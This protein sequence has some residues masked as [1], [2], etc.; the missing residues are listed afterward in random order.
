MQHIDCKK[1][2]QEILDAVKAVPNKK[3]LVILTVGNNPASQSYVKGKIK[4]CEYCGIPYEHIKIDDSPDAGHALNVAIHNANHDISV[5]GVIVQLP[6]PKHLDEEQYTNNVYASLDVDG[7]KANSPFKPC[8]PEGIMYVLRKELGDL[9]GKDALVI[10]RGK[11]V[12]EPLAKMLLDAN[13][14]VTVAHSKTTN[15]WHYLHTSDII[16]SAVG[17][18]NTVSLESCW[19]AEVVIDVGVNRDA[20]GK[21]VGDCYNFEYDEY[22][23][24]PRVTPVPNGI[25]LMTRAMLMAH[26]ARLDTSK[27]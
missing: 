8:T 12:G 9:T 7:F 14:T 21:L 20:N 23:T 22:I 15:L 19:N 13:C 4:D 17:K 6:L 1:Y 26:V 18:P 11:L 10:G 25:G 5:G 27:L 2:A 16:I 24:Y 3:K